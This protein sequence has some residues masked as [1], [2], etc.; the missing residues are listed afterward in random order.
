MFVGPAVGSGLLL[1]LGPAYGLFANILIYAPLTLWLWKAPYGPRF[2]AQQSAPTVAVRNVRDIAESIGH[3]GRYPVIATMTLLAGG[4][5]FFV[6]N[7]YQ[8]QMPGFAFDLGHGDPGMSY[9]ML[10]AADAAGALSAGLALEMFGLLKPNPRTALIL[11]LLWAF[12]LGRFAT[13]SLYPVALCLLFAAGF[14]ELSF[15]SMAQT[16]VQL[17]APPDMRG[18]MI[19]VYSMAAMGMRIFSG[20][21]V[22][23]VGASLGIHV[24]LAMSAA[25][26]AVLITTLL[27]RVTRLQAVAVREH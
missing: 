16:L 13:M 21:S 24:S 6:G 18:R 7:A 1:A 25:L 23:V 17:H 10:L 14:L 27:I 2:R 26:V 3:I 15:N 4:T 9:S 5:A 19:G 20:V 11:A 8:A 22:G 12:A